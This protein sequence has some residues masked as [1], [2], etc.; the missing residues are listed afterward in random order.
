VFKA[1]LRAL[2]RSFFDAEQ[3]RATLKNWRG[4]GAIYLLLLSAFVSLF[5]SAYVGYNVYHFKQNE[6]PEIMAQMPVITIREGHV[7]VNK[8]EPVIIQG[9]ENRNF[10]IVI[11]TKASQDDFKKQDVTLGLGEN[12]FIFKSKGKYQTK[13]L[14][15]MQTDL[16]IDNAFVN[17]TINDFLRF[18]P[19]A[20]Y[21]ILTISQFVG[22]LLQAFVIALVSYIVTALIKEEYDFEKRMRVA[23]LAMT[24][25]T[26]LGLV[27]LIV[28]GHQ[29]STWLTILM[30]LL[31]IYVM[32]LLMRRL[33]PAEPS[34]DIL[35]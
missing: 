1:Y 19:I 5:G 34:T 16:V 24:P 26:I 29:T 11:D 27:L 18:L 17:K 6:L 9:R 12:F 20:I 31:Y 14:T 3:Y 15:E 13:L 4:I 28:A 23:A 30:A 33:P 10:K 35:V 25:G 2:Y 8:E 22:Y 21:P 7:S 32:I